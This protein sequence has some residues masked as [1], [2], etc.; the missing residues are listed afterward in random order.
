MRPPCSHVHCIE[1]SLY[2]EI[3]ISFHSIHEYLNKINKRK[4]EMTENYKNKTI[5][6]KNITSLLLLLLPGCYR[7]FL[8]LEIIWIHLHT[9]IRMGK[10][11]ILFAIWIVN[12]LSI[13]N[14]K[15]S[16]AEWPCSAV[17]RKKNQRLSNS[18]DIFPHNKC[19]IRTRQY[20]SI[21]YAT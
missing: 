16:I 11:S 3:F 5:N 7:D 12:K 17:E 8:N 15:T 6:E 21:V 9:P 1:K 20:S 4:I 2:N 14:E 18:S 13:L 19:V 10:K